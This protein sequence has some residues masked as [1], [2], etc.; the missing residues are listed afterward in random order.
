MRFGKNWFR[1]SS[2]FLRSLDYEFLGTGW[3]KS[4]DRPKGHIL[5]KSPNV[6]GYVIASVPSRTLP[7]V[8]HS[9]VINMKGKVVHDPNPNKLWKNVNVLKSK[10]LQN[11]MMISKVKGK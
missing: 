8:G 6:K 11:W 5:A 9:V 2:N 3:V 1:V 4:K 10:K 7:N